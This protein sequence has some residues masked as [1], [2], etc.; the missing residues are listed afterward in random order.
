[1][2]LKIVLIGIRVTMGYKPFFSSKLIKSFLIINILKL[3]EIDDSIASILLHS[4]FY[5]IIFINVLSSILLDGFGKFTF[6]MEMYKSKLY[7]SKFSS[8]PVYM[9][10]D[11]ELFFQITVSS[12][13]NKLMVLIDNCYVTPFGS[14]DQSRKHFLIDKR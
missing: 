2:I 6:V 12:Q 11:E 5:S 1:M 4:L 13:D 3:K 10:L 14:V 9:T 8:Y 7:L